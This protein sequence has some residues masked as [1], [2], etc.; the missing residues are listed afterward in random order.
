MTTPSHFQESHKAP[1][2]ETLLHIV[3]SDY[4]VIFL[5][6]LPLYLKRRAYTYAVTNMQVHFTLVCSKLSFPA[7]MCITKINIFMTSLPQH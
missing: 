3:I 6:K 1:K 7:V 5:W 2:T 4:R